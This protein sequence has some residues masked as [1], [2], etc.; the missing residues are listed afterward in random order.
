MTRDTDI[1]LLDEAAAFTPSDRQISLKLLVHERM[2]P[3]VLGKL[4]LEMADALEPFVSPFRMA[5][6]SAWISK[7]PG[8]FEWLLTPDTYVVTMHKAREQAAATIIDILSVNNYDEEINPKVLQVKMKA[9]E[10]LLKS[11]MKREQRVQNTVKV[12]AML[13]RHLAN[14]SVD[15]LQEELRKLKE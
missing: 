14:K 3:Q 2:S 7:Y 11:D 12:N 9:A 10:L 5:E 15:A 6:V 1:L 8:F 4:T 13:P